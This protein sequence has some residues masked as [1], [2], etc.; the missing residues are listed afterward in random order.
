M[1]GI[2]YFQLFIHLF[3]GHNNAFKATLIDYKN[4]FCNYLERERRPFFRIM[5][6]TLKLPEKCPFGP[7]S[8]NEFRLRPE[9]PF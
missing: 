8:T 5:K 6:D 3:E 9:T 4:N 2:F 7:A 1:T